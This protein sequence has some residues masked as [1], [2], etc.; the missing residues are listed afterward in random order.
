MHFTLQD[1]NVSLVF[2]PTIKELLPRD[3]NYPLTYHINFTN[4]PS[5]LINKKFTVKVSSIRT[6]FSVSFIYVY[7]RNIH[8]LIIPVNT[9]NLLHLEKMVCIIC[10]DL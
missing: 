2:M 1:T 7:V 10:F 6:V 5:K 9:S 8:C 3:M 4:S